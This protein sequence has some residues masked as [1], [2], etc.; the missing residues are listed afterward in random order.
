MVADRPARWSGILQVT[1]EPHGASAIRKAAKL[2]SICRRFGE[3]WRPWS[4]RMLARDKVHRLVTVPTYVAVEA[5]ASME[6]KFGSKRS[7]YMDVV[8][9]ELK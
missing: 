1:R 7:F 3:Q 4:S 5:L 6:E 2:S 9:S 8:N